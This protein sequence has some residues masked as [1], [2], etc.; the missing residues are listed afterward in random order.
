MKRC[1]DRVGL[2]VVA[3]A[4]AVC[5]LGDSVPAGQSAPFWL[6]PIAARHAGTIAAFGA[7]QSTNWSGYNQGLLGKGTLFTSVSGDWT[8]PT[9][10]QH[11]TGR[12]ENSSAWVGIGGGCLEPSCLLVDPTLIQAG[13]NQ[14]VDAQNHAS[15]STWWEIIPL[16]QILTPLSVGP[17]DHVRVTIN[18]ALPEIWQIRIDNISSG[19]SFSTT[20]PYSSSYGTAEWI[21]ETPTMISTDSGVG[22]ASMPKLGSVPFFNAKANGANPNLDSSQAIQLVSSTG[23]IIA[24][25][26]APS[27]GDSF[28]VCT[29]SGSC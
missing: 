21:L 20:V 15:Y 9:A 4:F 10:S 27:G 22:L 16:P 25:P 26:S 11:T 17:G 24:T 29:Y 23:E 13:T 3:A 14:D 2:A 6:S 7:N 19:Q 28:R 18:Q 5:L 1:R 8:V 12:A